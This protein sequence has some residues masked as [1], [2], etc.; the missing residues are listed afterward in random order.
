MRFDDDELSVVVNEKSLTEIVSYIRKDFATNGEATLKAL[1]VKNEKHP[2]VSV[3][4]FLQYFE[5]DYLELEASDFT[6]EKFA[7]FLNKYK[8]ISQGY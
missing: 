3:D 2:Y 5:K 6:Y 7:N 1:K 8:L 4:F